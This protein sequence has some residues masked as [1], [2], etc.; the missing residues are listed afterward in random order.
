VADKY[1]VSA[2]A[3]AADLKIP[4]TFT[5]EKLGRLKKQYSFTMDD[6]KASIAAHKKR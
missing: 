1:N 6:V 4:A 5:G 3:I 2:E